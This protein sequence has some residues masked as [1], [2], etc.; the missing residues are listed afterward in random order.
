[1]KAL[2]RVVL[3]FLSL[4]LLIGCDVGRG[5]PEDRILDSSGREVGTIERCSEKDRITH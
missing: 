3:L 5:C 1:M 2:T 4:G